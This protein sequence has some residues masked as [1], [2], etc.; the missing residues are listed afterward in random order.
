MQPNDGYYRQWQLP[1]KEKS[2]QPKAEQEQPKKNAFNISA[3]LNQ[4]PSMNNQSETPKSADSQS[5]TPS[6][7]SYPPKPP[8]LQTNTQITPSPTSESP[9]TTLTFHQYEPQAATEAT[10]KRLPLR[11]R[12]TME[13]KVQLHQQNVQQPPPNPPSSTSPPVQEAPALPAPS[14]PAAPVAAAAQAAPP[15]PQITSEPALDSDNTET[16]EEKGSVEVFN[17]V[18]VQPASNESS[19]PMVKMKPLKKAKIW[20]SLDSLQGH[21]THQNSFVNMQS[22]FQI[23]ETSETAPD[24]GSKREITDDTDLPASKR[25]K[26]TNDSPPPAPISKRPSSSSSSDEL[27]CICRKPYDKPR[28]MIACDECD[29]WFHGECVGMS[30]R[31]GGLIELYYCPACSRG[32]N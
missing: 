7:E 22:Q 3:L 25:Q 8:S 30:E 18:A 21:A 4:E 12:L 5:S 28:F 16:D 20:G 24:S 10:A 14:A 17:P 6:M 32:K 19:P 9:S 31:D 15:P 2:D 26:P 1:S 11:K 27:Y 29:Q 23:S 13:S